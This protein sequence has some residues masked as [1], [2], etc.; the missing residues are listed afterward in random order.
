MQARPQI[1]SDPDGEMLTGRSAQ[2]TGFLPGQTALACN[3]TSTSTRW[4]VVID[5]GV[6]FD[7]AARDTGEQVTHLGEDSLATSPT[8]KPWVNIAIRLIPLLTA[9]GLFVG[10][11]TFWALPP[12]TVS[13]A[14]FVNAHTNDAQ[15]VVA[16]VQ[17]VEKA[18]RASCDVGIGDRAAF[19]QQL[20]DAKE[21][22]DKVGS[23][24][25]PSASNPPTGLESAY[26]EMENAAVQLSN[27]VSAA[28]SFVDSQK[29]SDLANYSK[30]WQQ[31]RKQWNEPVAK[32][33]SAA[34]KPPPTVDQ[35]AAAG[36]PSHVS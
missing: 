31:G 1:A 15:S 19:Q 28:S 4:P 9:L 17:A 23:S 21:S 26:N 18:M 5:K 7:C 24:L 36:C 29:P 14:D 33:W 3:G 32:I 2:R 8:V 30:Q 34:R 22:F 20:S 35:I 27:A 10:F 11:V 12:Q 25:M 13:P 6:S 16:G